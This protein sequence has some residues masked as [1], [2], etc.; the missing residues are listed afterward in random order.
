MW[1]E[2]SKGERKMEDIRKE[3]IRSADKDTQVFVIAE[4]SQQNQT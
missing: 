3:F 4:R 1:A 2:Y